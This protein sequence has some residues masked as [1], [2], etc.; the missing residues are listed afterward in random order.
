MR[1]AP[2]KGLG[3]KIGAKR[4]PIP[5]EGAIQPSLRIAVF[6]SG[7]DLHRIYE[8]AIVVCTIIN[9]YTVATNRSDQG[10]I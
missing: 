9:Y 4:I 3:W 7:I 6:P 1:V 10:A 8:V 5:N 2:K